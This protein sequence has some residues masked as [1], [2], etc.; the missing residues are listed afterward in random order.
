MSSTI[1]KK[2]LI[3][4]FEGG[5]KIY[6]GTL[7]PS[8]IMWSLSGQVGRER[9]NLSS[10]DSQFSNPN[11]GYNLIDF[12]NLV[13]SSNNY[14]S[15]VVPLYA[16]I[17]YKNLDITFS[18]GS[19]IYDST[20]YVGPTINGIISG[21]ENNEL[22]TI[23]TY[24]AFFSTQNVG[25]QRIDVSNVIIDGPTVTNYLINPIV[26]FYSNITKLKLVATFLNGDKNYDGT[27]ETPVLDYSLSGIIGTETIV[28]TNW[29][30]KFKSSN[31]GY[32]FIDISNV[33]FN[34]FTASNY[35][36]EPVKMLTAYISSIPIVASFNGGDKIYNSTLVTGPL[37]W[38]T[39]GM[40]NNEIITLGNYVSRY[41]NPSLRLPFE[42]AENE[43]W[44]CAFL[45]EKLY[46]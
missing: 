23:S 31:V 37:T 39:S 44:F 29:I 45:V 15:I 34:G 41:I 5:D 18:G 2:D 27:I 7:V 26:P 38:T 12:S 11:V 17:Y 40:V 33:S 25:R 36:L 4:T 19:K 46:S 3:V 1:Y 24:I 43:L 22:I 9:V 35:Y 10:F 6:D 20:R 32:Q 8:L 30:S 28:L 14:T 13:L 16:N 42:V 21:I